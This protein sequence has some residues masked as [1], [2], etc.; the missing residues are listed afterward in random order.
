MTKKDDIAICY[1]CGQKRPYP[2][3]QGRWKYKE[4]TAKNW[5]YVTV[6]EVEEGLEMTIDG[7]SEPSWWPN[8]A[9]WKKVT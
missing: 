6:R 1:C 4:T 8:N 7:D 3:K 2:T 5:T 9:Q